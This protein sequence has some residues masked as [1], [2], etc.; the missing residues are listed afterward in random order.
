MKDQPFKRGAFP[1]DKSKL[2]SYKY[3]TYQH[4]YQ[5]KRSQ[6]KIADS[7]TKKDISSDKNITDTDS[8]HQTAP[9][10]LKKKSTKTNLKN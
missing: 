1:L 9:P 8:D 7:P 3:P 10:L 5:S 6:T 4:Y 2:E